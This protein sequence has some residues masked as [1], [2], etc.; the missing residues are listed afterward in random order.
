[1]RPSIEGLLVKT[2]DMLHWLGKYAEANAVALFAR[3]LRTRGID[4]MDT[5]E[6]FVVAEESADAAGEGEP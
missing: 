4:D 2:A 3:W 5:L 6:A 1:M